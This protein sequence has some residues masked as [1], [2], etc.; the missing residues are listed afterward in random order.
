[1][2]GLTP[3]LRLLCRIEDIPDG[4]ARG[5]PPTPGMFTGVFAIRRGGQVLIYVNSCP[6]LGV[7]LE[8]MPDRFLSADGSLIVFSTHGA[9]FAVTDGRCLRGPCVGDRL[10]PV[11]AVLKNGDVL[12]PHDA[13]L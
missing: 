2:E 3:S 1:M 5:F 9:E 10:E 11:A 6:H 4:G 12:V 13:G 8:W 7:P